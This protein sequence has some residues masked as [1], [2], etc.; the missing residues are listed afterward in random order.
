MA[1]A[2]SI[3][4]RSLRLLGQLPAGKTPTSD[5]YADGLEALNAMVDAWNNESLL[6]FAYQAETL[7][8]ANADASYTIGTSGDLNTTRPV[9]IVNAYIVEANISYPVA[10]MNE[11]EYA[12]IADKTLAGD[13][14]T[15]LLFRPTIASSQATVIVWPVPNATRTMKLTTRVQVGSFASTATT[16]TL[17]PGWEKALAYNLAIDLAPEFETQPSAAVAKGAVESLA[18]IKRA[19]IGTRPRRL[20]TEIGAMFPGNAA[21]IVTD[22]A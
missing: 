8:L 14:P 6:C 17:P 16:V 5:E 9:E 1:T 15:H 4:E 18:G 13:W 20:Y 12:G 22:E 3:I 10:I 11:A 21:S 2:G 19:N 7:T